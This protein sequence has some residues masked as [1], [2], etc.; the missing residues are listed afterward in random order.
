MAGQKIHSVL[1]QAMAGEDL[2]LHYEPFD[3]RTVKAVD[4]IIEVAKNNG[5]KSH[6]QTSYDWKTIEFIYYVWQ[7]SYPTHYRDFMN[8]IHWFRQNELDHGIGGDKGARIQH[9]LEIPEKLYTM[10]MSV[11]PDQVWDRKF[12]MQFAKNLPDTKVI[13]DNY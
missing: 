9:Q 1:N 11:F 12:I 4:K 8:S 13:A 5:S 3:E 7:R 10:I 2:S 6:V